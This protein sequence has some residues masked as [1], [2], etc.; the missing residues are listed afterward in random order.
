M[1]D[2]AVRPLPEAP[3][4]LTAE[5]RAGQWFVIIVAMVALIGGSFYLWRT[6]AKPFQVVYS[7][8]RFLVGDEK[9]AA[10]RA[11]AQQTDTDGDGLSDF[12]ET[13][14]FFT[15][16]YLADSDSDGQSDANEVK[17]GSDPNCLP[18]QQCAARNEDVGFA[19]TPGF[20]AEQGAVAAQEL[21]RLQSL[22]NEYA[23]A[24]PAEVRVMLVDSGIPQAEVDSLDDEQVMAIFT[25]SFTQ[26]TEQT[27]GAQQMP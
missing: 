22:L 3:H 20:A 19:P 17:A 11:R 14:I 5:E 8:P 12:D 27:L 7:G 23:D 1:E 9:E 21:E 24:T 13:E 4:P 25:Q 10:E 18:G 6:I 26:L 2:P 16:P 15:S